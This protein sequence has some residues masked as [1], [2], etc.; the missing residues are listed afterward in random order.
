MTG[1]NAYTELA[2]AS[3]CGLA[4]YEPGKPPEALEREYGVRDAIKLA[5]NE[6]PFGAADS[7]RAAMRD[8]ID[9]VRLYPDGAGFALC[10]A[11]SQHLGV[12]PAQLTLGNGSNDILVLL[13]ECFLTPE[14]SAV[15]DR[16][17]FVVYRLAVQATGAEARIASSNAPDHAQP[18]GHDLD[19]M[20]AL[21]DET[22]RL[23]FIANP[24]NPTGTW[25]DSEMLHDFLRALPD[26]V[27]AV[28]D[29]AYYE[30]AVGE[31]Y[32][33]TLTW[34]DQF[35]NLVIL[36]TFSKAYGLAGLRV[37]Y[38]ISAPG[39]AELLNRVRQPFNV[40]SVAQAA[41][42][43]AL[44]EQ[45][46][47]ENCRANNRHCMDGLRTGLEAL[48]IAC[49]PSRGNFLLAYVGSRAADCNE[50][51]LRAGVIVR[52]VANY[53]LPEY[54]RITVGGEQD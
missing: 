47:V 30:Y 2:A 17:S 48:G 5:S 18:F 33:D 16:Y 29:E 24:N 44:A 12:D 52:P 43:Q 19:A 1:D 50:Y 32:P 36:R 21:V 11:L 39:I 3:V 26:H 28:V 51:L 15:Y 9:N 37:G 13:A 54:L 8:A 49:L 42:V 4:P 46:W 31:D 41:A 35:P 10:K 53:G 45:D 23:V 34:L 40:N 27:I 38:G 22:T 20:L 6:N 14:T 7:V 25:V